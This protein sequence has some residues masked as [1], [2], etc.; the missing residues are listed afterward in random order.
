M[1]AG[2]ILAILLL[3]VTTACGFPHPSRI[4]NTYHGVGKASSDQYAAR[5]PQ[6][7]IHAPSAGILTA[8]GKKPRE[9]LGFYTEPEGDYP[10]S[11]SIVD[12]QSALLSSIAPFWYKLNEKDP[13][14]LISSV[15]P[16]H[17]RQVIQQAHDQGLHVYLLVHNLFYSTPEKGKAVAHHILVNRSAQQR[18]L[19]NLEAEIALYGYD[20]VNIDIENLYPGDKR[21]FSQ[22]IQ[23]LSNR[24]H[25]KG[26]IVTVSVPA[27]TGDDRANPWSHWFDYQSLGRSVDRLVIMTYDEHN[28]RTKPGPV[29]S[30]D[31]TEDTIRYALKQQI[32]PQKILLGVAS[33]GWSWSGGGEKATYSSFPLLMQQK[34]QYR[35]T[36]QWDAASQT[37]MFTFQDEANQ[38]HTSWFENSASLRFKLDLVEKYNLQGIG[39]WRLGLEDPAF[40]SAIPS[41]IKVKKMREKA[42]PH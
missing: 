9:V 27:N 1:R 5:H 18:F 4:H 7:V 22:M 6:A 42:A 10:G 32:P 41:K 34:A 25:Q 36:I 21:A 19:K 37:P 33:Y 2:F 13:A 16:D 29:A 3:F 8:A 28:P 12:A 15:P 14:Q 31:W 30:Y 38:T 40:W 35:A 24:L 11:Q 23:Q 39:I 26:K 20:G 17:Q